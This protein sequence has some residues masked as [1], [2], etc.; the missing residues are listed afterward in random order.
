MEYK[1]NMERNTC[2]TGEQCRITV[3]L[4]K[5]EQYYIA[6]LVSRG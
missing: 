3:E 4:I 5:H 1:I 6:F 2:R